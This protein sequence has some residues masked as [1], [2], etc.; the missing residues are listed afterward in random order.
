[1][2]KTNRNDPKR[3]GGSESRYTFYD[4]ERDFPD[5]A[6]CLDWLVGHLY[7]EGIFCPKCQKV[8]KHHR[9]KTR[10]C[11]ACQFCGH[12][13]YPMRGTIFEDSATSLRVWFHAFFL[14]AETRCGISAKQIERETGVT[15]KTAWRMANKIRSLLSSDADAPF[16]GSVE[17]DEAYVGGRAYWRKNSDRRPRKDGRPTAANGMT[18]VLG[19][20]QRK[21]EGSPGKV[22][23]RI[24]PD[25]AERT[26][27][28]HVMTK[29]LPSTAVYTDEWQG[30]KAL[31]EAGYEHQ[32]IRHSQKVY[33]N[34][35]VHTNTIEGFWSLLKR[36]IVGV[37][38]GV[39]TTH[40]Q[41][42]MDE[43]TFR[44]NHREE[45][46]GMFR[47]FLGQIEKAPSSRSTADQVPS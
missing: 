19:I 12:Q 39:S 42:Y 10:T 31:G 2:S 36:G 37:Y 23:A 18:P 7:P 16:E 34:G 41:S 5:D 8:T 11:Y 21:T 29:V 33:V 27:V 35:D 40:L 26:L 38:H 20:A 9:V 15:Y 25:A 30:Y 47:T 46:V 45:P 1:M 22:Y 17:A 14:M 44:Y 32:R 3:A 4:F 6:A 43:Y 24:V 28:P 13:E